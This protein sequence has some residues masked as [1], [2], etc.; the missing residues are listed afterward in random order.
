MKFT[1]RRSFIRAALTM[2]VSGAALMG[3]GLSAD[4]QDRK[5]ITIGYI[6]SKTGVNAPGAQITNI[7]SYEMWA[8][9]V[10]AAGGLKLPD[11][12]KLPVKFI[13]YDDRS[14]TEEVVRGVERLATQDKVD[15][16]LS[17][18]GTAFN[19]AVAPLMD[20]FGYPHLAV[21]ATTHNAPEFAKRWKK[22]F[23]FL[24][25]GKDY[26]VPLADILADQKGNG[27][28]NNKVALI[29]IADGFGIDLVGEARPALKAKG[30]DIVFDKTYPLGT[31]DFG[32]LIAE[33][34]ASGADTFISLSYPP[35]TFAVTKQAMLAKF[36]P[37][38]FYV[39]VGGAFP[40]YQ[41]VAGASIEGIIA[42]GG[43][44]PPVA[45][46]LGRYQ[47][48]VGKGADFWAAPVIYSSLQMLQQAIERKG[49]DRAA[50]AA[51]LSNG[52]FDTVMGKIKLKDN[53]YR[54]F[55]AGGQWQSGKFVGVAPSTKPGA[56]KVIVPKPAW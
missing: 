21:T 34:K 30:F 52:T 19:L 32:T 42:P 3:A 16:I 15:F 24:G 43:I 27:A 29:S 13:T 49:L 47:S 40:I 35:D 54:D 48:V 33:A 9:E 18:W 46:F 41:N 5:E 28:I 45:E 20:R 22:S 2:A 10:N 36:N 44:D 8:H 6:V 31:Q 11:G 23:W 4:A 1:C 25:G 7:G 39:G 51:E 17:P 12:K 26:M 55:W 38:V 53:Q 50:V 56:A 37:K 14:S